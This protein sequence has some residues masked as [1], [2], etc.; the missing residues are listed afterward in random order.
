M[1][2]KKI[3]TLAVCFLLSL[4]REIKKN[5]WHL[6]S[7]SSIWRT[8]AFLLVTLS[9]VR[10]SVLVIQ[11]VQSLPAMQETLGSIIGSRRSPGEGNGNLLQYSC[12][13]NP[14]NGGAWQA[15]IYEI[16]KSRTWLGNEHTHS[17]QSAYI[18]PKDMHQLR[19]EL[20]SIPVLLTPKPKLF[21][22]SQ[23]FSSNPQ[24]QKPLI[25]HKEGV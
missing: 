17:R 16:A 10:Q 25:E 9:L 12:V 23:V 18:F 4:K 22:P 24:A 15:P 5:V 2:G 1:E 6:Q 19:E 8:L 7:V 21:V 13:E 14:M 20:G 11:T 3:L